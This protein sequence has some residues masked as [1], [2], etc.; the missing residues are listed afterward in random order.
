MILN[1][2]RKHVMIGADYSQQE[3]KITADLSNDEQ[4]IK[5]CASGKDAYSTIASIAFKLP[6]EDCLEWKLDENGNKT[7]EVNKEGKE[8]RG[9]AKILLLG[10]CYGKTMKSIASDLNVSEEKAQEIYDAV[11]TNIPGLKNFMYE[12]QEM[13]RQ[14]GY[15]EDKWGRRR[16]LPDM[17]LPKYEITSV[18]TKSFDP[19]FD[20]KELGVVDEIDILK[21]DIMRELEEAKYYNQKLKIEDKANKLGLK[22]KENTKKIEDAT[23]QCVNSRV[24][25]SAATQTK[26]AM[27][28]I[29]TNERLKQLGFK[30]I[31]LVHDEILGEVPLVAAKEAIPLFTQCM[32]DAAKDLRTGAKCDCEVTWRWYG[33]TVDLDNPIPDNPIAELK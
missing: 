11:L 33:E 17:Q 27:K 16:H 12:S 2:K 29:G 25:G 15:V 9:I 4:F 21:Q 8:R 26:I 5:D 3:P 1:V 24:Q 28:L 22:I 19:F 31:L 10:I 20:S 23:R 30:M 18:G 13:A 6:Y 14:L 32:L 7:H